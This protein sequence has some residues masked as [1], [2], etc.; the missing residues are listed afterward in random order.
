MPHFNEAL[1]I[2][3]DRAT[4]MFGMGRSFE[5]L[6]KSAPAAGTGHLGAT[7]YPGLDVG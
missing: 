5:R 2:L 1:T 4:D 6:M 3:R 7:V